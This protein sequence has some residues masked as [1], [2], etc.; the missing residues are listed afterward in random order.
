M[1]DARRDVD[2]LTCDNGPALL[3]ETYLAG[4]FDDEVDLFLCMVMPGDLA[5]SRI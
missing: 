5:T 4:S 2:G 1:E 3:S